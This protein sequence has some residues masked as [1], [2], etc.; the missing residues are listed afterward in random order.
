M[1]SLRAGR[2]AGKQN[3]EY[4]SLG[5]YNDDPQIEIGDLNFEQVVK[6][7]EAAGFTGAK[8]NS[9]RTHNGTQLARIKRM[10]CGSSNCG[11]IL[12][13]IEEFEAPAQYQTHSIFIEVTGHIGGC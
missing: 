2:V 9:K 12:R 4:F 3:L 7:M 13:V 5:Y 11:K 1:L 10:P 8:S 6:R